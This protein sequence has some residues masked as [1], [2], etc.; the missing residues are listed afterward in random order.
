MYAC[1]HA[2][3]HAC[4]HVCVSYFRKDFSGES[5]ESDLIC[6]TDRLSNILAL[7]FNQA[8]HDV[9]PRHTLLDGHCKHGTLAARKVATFS[10][11]GSK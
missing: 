11:N 5:I 4:V 8:S 1:M 7:N 10:T 9:I 3:V 6:A 2:C